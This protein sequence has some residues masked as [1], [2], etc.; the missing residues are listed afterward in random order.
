MD[1][2]AAPIA[3]I[4]NQTGINLIAMK[5]ISNGVYPVSS[6]FFVGK[7]YGYCLWTIRC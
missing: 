7:D 1:M 3:Q 4:L 6:I 5:V 2:E